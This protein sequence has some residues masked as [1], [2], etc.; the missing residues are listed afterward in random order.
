MTAVDTR[1][2]V[3]VHI[4]DDIDA[5]DV[6]PGS[7]EVRAMGGRVYGYGYTCPGCGSRSWLAIGTE[8]P[9]PR[10]SVTAGDA[11]RPDTVT[12]SP[13]IFHTAERGG[14]GW[15]GYLTDGVLRPC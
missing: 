3:P 14:C 7:V 1:R 13:S 8:E 5:P 2:T 12:L 4:V 10:W 6:P 9:H 15:H 11:A